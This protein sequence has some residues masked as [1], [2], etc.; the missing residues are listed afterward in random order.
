MKNLETFDKIFY[1]FNSAFSLRSHLLVVLGFEVL[2]E[3]NSD[4]K[5][6]G[7]E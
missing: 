2:L 3:H 1:F 5:G 6:Q 7:C 4:M